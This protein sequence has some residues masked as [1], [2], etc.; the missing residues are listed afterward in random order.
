[1]TAWN[2][3]FM[4]TLKHRWCW[5]CSSLSLIICPRPSEIQQTVNPVIENRNEERDRN[6]A[7]QMVRQR[8]SGLTALTIMSSEFDF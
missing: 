8:T 5:C 1:M 6:I 7:L 2:S 3:F 4:V